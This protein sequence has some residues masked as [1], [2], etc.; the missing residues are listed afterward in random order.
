M[1]II[2]GPIR[3]GDGIAPAIALVSPK[4]AHN[5]GAAVRAASCYGVRQV[6]F[7]GDRVRVDGSKANRLPRE[8][9]MRGYGEVEIRQ[10]DYFFDAFTDVTPVAVEL[11]E[12]SESLIAFEH[13]ANAL[14]V[15][16]P[17]D[18]SLPRATLMHCHRFV[19]IPM[20]HCANLAGAV[21]T[22]LYDRHAK[23]VRAGQ[24]HPYA[25]E[26]GFDEPGAIAAVTGVA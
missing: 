26:S 25:P 13:P 11:R 23:R 5:V 8:E 10:G 7:T 9:R 17:E 2:S 21:Y 16:G 19:V 20:R 22:V 12:G 6:W 1:S 14:Y 18:G 4:Y 15:F 24:E 3:R